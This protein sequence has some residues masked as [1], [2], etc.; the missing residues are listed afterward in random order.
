LDWSNV[1]QMTKWIR[2]K[3]EYKRFLPRD[4]APPPEQKHNSAQ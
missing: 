4:G 3:Y 1:Q 2:D